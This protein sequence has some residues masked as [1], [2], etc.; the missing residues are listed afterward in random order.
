MKN[1]E[2]NNIS[3]EPIIIK[4]DWFFKAEIANRVF[5]ISIFALMLCFLLCVTNEDVLR[6]TKRKIGIAICI[7]GIFYAI[8]NN[9][10][11][12]W[13]MKNTA[14]FSKI[15][16]DRI[17]YEYLKFDGNKYTHTMPLENAKISYSYVPI[18]G[19]FKVEDNSFLDVFLKPVI[20]VANL[21]KKIIFWV[22]NG[23]RREKYLVFFYEGIFISMKFNDYLIE[24]FKTEVFCETSK[25]S[26]MIGYFLIENKKVS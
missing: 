13:A 20:F 18:F 19:N 1:K 5:L 6:E 10:K 24:K 14:L 4:N 21:V 23:V 12:F 8:F 22:L 11:Y 9:L 26:S 3:K 15:Y 2:K 25:F 16:V 17:E 7:G